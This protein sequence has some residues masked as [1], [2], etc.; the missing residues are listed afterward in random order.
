MPLRYKF[1]VGSI[2]MDSVQEKHH[3]TWCVVGYI[4]NLFKPIRDPKKNLKKMTI[5]NKII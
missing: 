3:K 5:N 4:I 2:D 1:S